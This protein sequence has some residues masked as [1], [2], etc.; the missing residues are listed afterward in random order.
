M[1]KTLILS[2]LASTLLASNGA[3]ACD[4][5]GCSVGVTPP[6]LEVSR[7][8]L[9]RYHDS[10]KYEH[11]IAAVDQKALQYLKNRV[12]HAKPSE[13]LA[14]VLDIDET[15]LSNYR[16]MYDMNFGGSIPQ[17]H[18]AEDKGTDAAINPTL[19]IFRYAKAH[20]IAVFFVTGRFEKYRHSTASNL[21][22]V[23]F[24][25]SDGLTMKPDDYRERSVVPY[26]SA[27]RKAIA[28]KGYTIIM[29]VGDQES[30]LTG[31]Y[32]EKTFKLPDPYYFIA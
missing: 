12:A 31:G 27:A 18:E 19:E 20:N 2:F 10:G 16:D 5:C 7:Q 29:N 26:K 3:F 9:I 30:D 28:D 11:Q 22:N 25:H 21:A 17:I 6:N 23:G 15:S 13:K 1:K 8:Q 32:A 14:I 24:V 4:D